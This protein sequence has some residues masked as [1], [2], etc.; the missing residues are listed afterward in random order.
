MS[1]Q[2]LYDI[3]SL[4]DVFLKSK[5]EV[6]KG[7]YY[8]PLTVDNFQ[9]E[10]IRYTGCEKPMFEDEIKRTS[11]T[12]RSNML[13]MLEHGS[14]YSHTPFHPELFL[15]DVT[16]DDRGVN[17]EPIA[18]KVTD[19]NMY[20]HKKYIK[21]QNDNTNN[22]VEGLVDQKLV[23][24]LVKQGFGKTAT[25]YGGILDESQDALHYRAQK[26]PGSATDAELSIIEA[27]KYYG[28][29]GEQVVA[30]MGMNPVNTISNLIGAQWQV[31]PDTQF[32][33]SSVS[34]LYRSKAEVDASVGA[35]FKLAKQESDFKSE[36]KTQQS[37]PMIQTMQAIRQDK[38]NQM[39]TNVNLTADSTQ[40][41]APN[42]VD[43]MIGH[44]GGKEI[45]ITKQTQ[46]KR[47]EKYI[48][49]RYHKQHN[50]N[51]QR[52]A[53]GI[54]SEKFKTRH[55][56]EVNQASALPTKDKLKIVRSIVRDNKDK[57][58]DKFA[59]I[60]SINQQIVKNAM[61]NKRTETLRENK[62][63][64][65][66][67]PKSET[68][69]AKQA[70]RYAPEDRV[71]ERLQSKSKYYSQTIEHL[72]SNQASNNKTQYVVNVNN[73]EFDTDPTTDNSYLDIKGVLPNQV[74]LN[75]EKVFD[76]D[77]SELAE[78]SAFTSKRSMF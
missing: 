6:T 47:F 28:T 40:L 75:K 57:Y 30:T 34:N 21:M 53:Q 37:K 2:A 31:Q 49:Q 58:K 46:I 64:H 55:D 41:A 77:I 51:A 66:S 11:T 60:Y 17:N 29:G 52:M 14:R 70:T 59:T 73:Y 4:P 19:Q 26:A 69:V 67:T 16:P 74:A 68:S 35:V 45:L 18:S 23:A 12:H 39:S 8:D 36:S 5:Y 22:V 50:P 76:N 63:V 43:K 42:K 38:Q 3:G 27:Q 48:N 1:K 72:I 24:K 56:T 15:G 71:S 20:R 10:A 33:V 9:K 25:Q 13:S 54:Q 65:A 62:G 7:Y 61:T 78:I 32:K 44:K